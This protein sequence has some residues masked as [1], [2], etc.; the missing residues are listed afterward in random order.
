MNYRSLPDSLCCEFLVRLKRYDTISIPPDDIEG[1]RKFAAD[2]RNAALDEA[3]TTVEFS[4]LGWYDGDP[5]KRIAKDI[6]D[7]Y[8][9]KIDGN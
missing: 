1:V 7:L 8:A 9:P 6:R 4:H 3:A 5:R 2:I